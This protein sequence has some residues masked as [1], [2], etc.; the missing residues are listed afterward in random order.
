MTT[1][2]NAEKIMKKDNDESKTPASAATPAKP[3]PPAKKRPSCAKGGGTAKATS[4]PAAESAPKA[5]AKAP[6]AKTPKPGDG[7]A[8]HCPATPVDMAYE[9]SLPDDPVYT[10]ALVHGRQVERLAVALFRELAPL[11]KLG[12]PWEDRLRA[13][14][15]LHDI[16]W[17]EG[18]KKHHKTS[19]RLI[20]TD[21][22]L[23]PDEAERPLVALLARYHRRAW[24]SPRHRRFAALSKDERKCV[25]RL[26][27]LLRLADALDYSRQGLVEDVSARIGKKRVELCLQA[28]APCPEEMRRAKVKGDL[29]EAEFG[30]ELR[31]SCLPQ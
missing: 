11:H 30:R 27:A 21:P 20:E 4:A 1:P 2:S 3:A 24:P 19:M 22:A 13:A 31:C 18:R 15:R 23:V 8:A 9:P 17:V 29:F 25:L 28:K 16:G 10:G 14:A 5:A 7:V 12:A 26:A 6:A